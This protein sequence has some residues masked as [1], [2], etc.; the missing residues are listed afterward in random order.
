MPPKPKRRNVYLTADQIKRLADES[1]RYRSLVLLLGTAGLR[2]G[3]AAV[4]RVE[5]IDFLRRRIELQRNA[6]TIGQTTHVG[7]LKSGKARTVVL[8]AFVVDEVARMCDGT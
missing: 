3:E 5:D 6:V 4:M 8:E 7:T 2:W 1:G